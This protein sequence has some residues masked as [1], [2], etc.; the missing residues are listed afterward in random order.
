MEVLKARLQVMESQ[1]KQQRRLIER[2]SEL[3]IAF[4][5]YSQTNR[6]LA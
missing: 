3:I 5:R 1:L 4:A 2:Q 6:D